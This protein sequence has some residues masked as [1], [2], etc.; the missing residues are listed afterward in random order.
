MNIVFS[1][2]I[3]ASETTAWMSALRHEMPGYGW[4]DVAEVADDPDSVEAAVVANPLPGSLSRFRRLRLIQS[5]WAGVD[6]LVRDPTLPAS[7]PVARMVDPAMSDAMA[8]TALWATLSLHRGFFEYAARQQRRQWQVH[9][10]ARADETPVLVLGLGEMGGAVARRLA[11]QGYPVTGWVLRPRR[12]PVPGILMADGTDGLARALSGAA[13]VIN[14]LPLTA[15]T[16]GLVDARFL[17]AMAPSA[18]LVNLGR[19]AH[20]V[21]A[22][23]LAAL[24]RGHVRHAVLDVFR[25]E[26]LPTDHPYWSHPAVTLLPH[27]AALTDPRSAAQVVA[28]NLRAL[29]EGRP[30]R[31]LV[32]RARGY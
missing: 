23:L 26:P 21:D 25:T 2:D 12:A 1:G 16:E 10:Q 18:S 11:A 7:V 13:I 24:D 22:D 31:H 15:A 29:V 19:G 3:D 9:A 4:L 28:S 6:R 27:A 14:L 5:L 20:V 17:A 8:Q 30:L 32:D